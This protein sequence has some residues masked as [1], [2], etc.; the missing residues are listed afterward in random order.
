MRARRS[1]PTSDARARAPQGVA[2][3]DEPEVLQTD[4]A[5]KANEVLELAR[6]T[7]KEHDREPEF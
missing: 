1:A 4:E 2:G 5:S 6:T 3:E 7:L